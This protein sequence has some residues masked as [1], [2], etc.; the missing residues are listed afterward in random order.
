MVAEKLRSLMRGIDPLL[1][2]SGLTV[3]SC[4]GAAIGLVYAAARQPM[5]NQTHLKV[6]SGTLLGA[7]AATAAYEV[8]SAYM[9]RRVQWY[10]LPTLQIAKDVPGMVAVA[11]GARRTV[12]RLSEDEVVHYPRVEALLRKAPRIVAA[13]GTASA[14]V[15]WSN[16][17]HLANLDKSLDRWGFSYRTLFCAPLVML[18]FTTGSFGLRASYIRVTDPYC[19]REV[20]V[21]T[22][23]S[24]GGLFGVGCAALTYMLWPTFHWVSGRDPGSTRT[25][26]IVEGAV[27]FGMASCWLMALA[28]PYRGRSQVDRSIEETDQYYET[29]GYVGNAV[30]GNL[31]PGRVKIAEWKSLLQRLRST[32]EVM[33]WYVQVQLEEPGWTIS[34]VDR[35]CAETALEILGLSRA[36]SGEER[37]RLWEHIQFMRDFPNRY[38]NDLPQQAFSGERAIPLNASRLALTLADPDIPAELLPSSISESQLGKHA[39]ARITAVCAVDSELLPEANCR[40][41]LEPAEEDLAMYCLAMA[42]NLE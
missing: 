2:K 20:R 11:Y 19:N 9:P 18:M 27:W 39:W 37:A 14:I 17:D 23:F 8:V 3:L 35:H 16:P 30:G 13:T 29:L 42:K 5:L 15:A 26:V 25:Y 36:V 22:L 1:L 6:A 4:A 21:R 38:L 7:A 28:W 31:T 24:T 32:I 33:E 10:A 12:D 40:A 41:V 34:E